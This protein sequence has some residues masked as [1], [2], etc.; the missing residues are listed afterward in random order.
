MSETNKHAVVRFMQLLSEGRV[1]PAAACL[2]GD[3]KWRIIATSRPGVFTRAQL[4]GAIQ[5]LIAASSDGRFSMVPIGM[6]AEGEK[7]AV[8][9]ES[10]VNLN[11]GVKYNNKYHMLWTFKDGIAVECREYNDT[12]HVM[13]VLSGVLPTVTVPEISS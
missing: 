10:V 8:E 7:V 1:E 9:A 5:A 4:V 3:I 2:S 12:A 6:I 13:A 11:N